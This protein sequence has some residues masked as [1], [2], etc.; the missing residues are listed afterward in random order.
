MCG[1]PDRAEDFNNDRTAFVGARLHEWFR[2]ELDQHR[3]CG[4]AEAV[5][6][7]DSLRAFRRRLGGF[8]GIPDG[9]HGSLDLACH[10]LGRPSPD[11]RLALEMVADAAARLGE[12]W[13]ELRVNEI[14]QMGAALGASS[15]GVILPGT[16]AES[17]TA[18]PVPGPDEIVMVEG[19]SSGPE[20]GWQ[21]CRRLLSRAAISN[22]S[23]ADTFGD[24]SFRAMAAFFTQQAS[25]AAAR[26]AAGDRETDDAFDAMLKRGVS[27]ARPHPL[28]LYAAL[29]EYLPESLTVPENRVNEKFL[30]SPPHSAADPIDCGNPLAGIRLGV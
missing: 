23:Y 6:L 19:R 7:R 4:V 10:A 30:L 12:V 28:F 5:R 20:N 9:I 24:P 11:T 14:R 26:S 25:L 1:E 18:G 3:D 15:A 8:A 2:R 13:G 29:R 22:S 21:C 17:G 16:A 27:R